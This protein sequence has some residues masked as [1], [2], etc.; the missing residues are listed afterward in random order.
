MLVALLTNLTALIT[1]LRVRSLR[2]TPHNLLILNLIAADLG[3]VFLAMPFSLKSVFDHGEGLEDTCCKIF[4]FFALSFGY[5]HFLTIA[6]I[7]VDR[8]IVV[9]SCNKCGISDWARVRVMLTLTWL[10]AS[11]ISLPPVLKTNIGYTDELKMCLP[12][13]WKSDTLSQNILTMVTILAI[14]LPT[15][16]VSYTVIAVLLW[17]RDRK[18]TRRRRRGLKSTVRARPA[19][20][21]PSSPVGL[22]KVKFDITFADTESVDFE[23]NTPQCPGQQVYSPVATTGHIS[24]ETERS[25]VQPMGKVEDCEVSLALK[26]KEVVKRRR[27][28]VV[29][30]DGSTLTREGASRGRY[31]LGSRLSALLNIKRESSAKEDAVN[32]GDVNCVIKGF[33]SA[34]GTGFTPGTSLYTAA[35]GE[36]DIGTT[37]R[38]VIETRTRRLSN[39]FGS[40]KGV[41]GLGNH[42]RDYNDDDDV[43]ENY[44]EDDD[45]TC[46]FD[47][48]PSQTITTYSMSPSG[49]DFTTG[50]DDESGEDVIR[51][52]RVR[53]RTRKTKLEKL[54]IVRQRRV[55]WTGVLLVCC[56]IFFTIPLFIWYSFD[57]TSELFGV[58][59]VWWTYCMT[60]ADP[61]VYA[62]MNRRV[63]KELRM[64]RKS[65]ANCLS[66]TCKGE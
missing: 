58:L 18:L 27:K 28:G 33:K 13:D 20:P 65:M 38:T 41:V 10:I 54:R 63:K 62:F 44:S 2:Q 14:V 30:D 50:K 3:R 23:Q 60:I 8:V 47:S 34:H 12:L 9:T 53:R 11:T 16:I 57:S 37:Y 4:G 24:H 21:I 22:R 56:S 7:A 1:I 42:G 17:K 25:V 61:M 59:A 29:L 5:T 15:M 35:T 46:D 51:P 66:C 40:L 36:D 43:T 49:V 52:K 32:D 19:R 31:G 6:F 26:D 39:L 48:E 45:Q 55:A 64:Y